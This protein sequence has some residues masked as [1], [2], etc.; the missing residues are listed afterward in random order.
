MILSTVLSPES[1]VNNMSSDGIVHVKSTDS[2]I[3][4]PR[5]MTIKVGSK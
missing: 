5:V 4:G 1:Y 3:D 2:H